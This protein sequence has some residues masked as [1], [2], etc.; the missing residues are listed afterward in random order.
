MADRVGE[1]KKLV[2][3]APYWCDPQHLGSIRVERFVRWLTAAGMR[4]MLVAGGEKDNW[5][6]EAWGT[7]VT[8][9]DPLGIYRERRTN[10]VAKPPRPHLLRWPAYAL[11]SPDPGVVWAWRASRH[12]LVIEHGAGADLVISSSVPESSHVAAARIAERCAARLVVDM[13]DGWLD[14]PMKPFLRHS[15][16]RRLREG[17]LE[18]RI[19]RQAAV[20]LV[21]SEQWRRL[22]VQRLPFTAEKTVTLTNAYPAGCTL[23][24]ASDITVRPR[25]RRLTLLYAG[26][27]FTSRAERRIEHLLAPLLAGLQGCGTSGTL[28]FVGNLSQDEVDGL[29]GWGADLQQA[30]WAIA[31]RAALPRAAALELMRQADGLLLLSSSHASIPAKLFDYLCAQRPILALAPAAS[32][33]AELAP[34]LRQL[35]AL[36]YR[37]AAASPVVA[38]FVQACRSGQSYD[39]PVQFDE[40]HLQAIFLAALGCTDKRKS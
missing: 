14:E 38:E 4:V 27:I 40:A 25:E 31:T 17:V 21:T 28:S 37:D 26:R 34:Q 39:M 5:R 19:L 10:P 30:G 11:L 29:N 3:V 9:R 33:V 24:G 2:I 35:F 6:E 36:D 13:R 7:L 20:I 32:A 22:L 15:P 8:V 12:P 16:L 18:R 23:P 1:S